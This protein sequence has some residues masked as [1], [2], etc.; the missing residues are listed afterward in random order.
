MA[1]TPT[2]IDARERRFVYFLLGRRAKFV[3]I[4]C[5]DNVKRRVKQIARSNPIG[6]VGRLLGCIEGDFSVEQR[7]HETFAQYHER[8]DWF[9]YCGSLRRMLD[10]ITLLPVAD[11]ASVC[12]VQ[13][14]IDADLWHRVRVQAAIQGIT[15]RAFIEASLRRALALAEEAES[16]RRSA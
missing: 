3:K 13:L 6:K 4:G 7:L 10:R 5:S 9:R 2:S 12:A 14:H 8:G 11:A 15:M 16:R 1:T